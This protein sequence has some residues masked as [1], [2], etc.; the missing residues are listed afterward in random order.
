[1]RRIIFILLLTVSFN[2]SVIN[3]Q[4]TAADASGILEKLYRRLL[5]S[6]EDADRLRINDSIRNIID[7]YVTSDTVFV[8]R[9]T[10][11]RYLG[12][13][14]SPDSFLKIITWNL[15]LSNERSR[16][17][18]YFIRKSESGNVNRIFRLTGTYSEDPIRTDTT[19]SESDWYGA[20]Y[21]DLRPVR[22]TNHET[23]IL[24]GIDYGNS[25]ITRKIIEVLN[26]TPEGRI[27]FGK[28]CFVAGDEV[29]YREVLEYGS[30]VVISLRFASDR[31]IVFDHLVPFSAGSEDNRQYYGPDYSY[32]SYNFEN[33]IWKLAINVDAR[34]KK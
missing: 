3:G 12:Q 4:V 18:C 6:H 23:W 16:Y 10:N 34:N 11:L 5:T 1:M 28:K 30:N 7:N 9:F 24:L 22:K 8:H 20:L 2:T 26:F 29:K 13:I 25:F 32:D 17:F 14:T 27:I 21:Y 19:Y 31:S 33:G 15:I